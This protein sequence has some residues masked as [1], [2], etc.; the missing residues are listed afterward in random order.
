MLTNTP[1]VDATGNPY[2]N[3]NGDPIPTPLTI[4]P[5]GVYDATTP[6]TWPPLVRIVDGINRTRAN[7][8]LAFPVFPNRSFHS[9]GDILAVP[10][11]TV[12]SPFL[13][14]NVQPSSVELCADRCRL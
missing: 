13:N 1:W 14:T 11:L 8:N 6:I 7:T 12:A 9:L 5:A 2:R 3:A 4:Q 10:E